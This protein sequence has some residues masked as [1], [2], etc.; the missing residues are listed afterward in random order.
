MYIDICYTEFMT[1]EVASVPEP[2]K[3]ISQ[4]RERTE[5]SQ[6][7]SGEK[8]LANYLGT[9]EY[10]DKNSKVTTYLQGIM[11][12]LS[13]GHPV[14]VIVVH[15][16]SANAFVVSGRVVVHD[17]LLRALDTHE[18]I[19]GILDHE[20]THIQKGHLNERGKDLIGEVGVKRSNET[21]ADF[22]PLEH[23]DQKGINPAGLM[24]AFQKIDQ[25]ET[26]KMQEKSD[27]LLP[28]K[29]K[30]K[31]GWE[32][33]RSKKKISLDFE[34]GS[35][36]DRKLNLEEAAWLVDIRNLSHEMTLHEITNENLEEYQKDQDIWKDFRQFSLDEKRHFLQRQITKLYLSYVPETESDRREFKVKEEQLIMWQKEVLHEAFPDDTD[37]KIETKMLSLFYFSYL[38]PLNKSVNITGNEISLPSFLKRFQ[39]EDVIRD[40]FKAQE[41]L[42][43]T[44]LS[45]SIDEDRLRHAGSYVFYQRLIK[46]DIVDIPTYLSLVQALPE[47]QQRLE[48]FFEPLIEVFMERNQITSDQTIQHLAAN[49]YEIPFIILNV[50]SFLDRSPTRKENIVIE[51]IEG[52]PPGNDIG[53]THKENDSSYAPTI[54]DIVDYNLSLAGGRLGQEIQKL[55]MRKI[56]SFSDPIDA[57]IYTSQFPDNTYNSV[58]EYS[59]TNG[60][61]S[62]LRVVTESLPIP[63]LIKRITALSPDE[64]R[65]LLTPDFKR[66]IESMYF[67]ESETSLEDYYEDSHKKPTP[68]SIIQRLELIAIVGG[69]NNFLDRLQ[70]DMESVE[71]FSTKMSLAQ[72]LDFLHAIQ[73]IPKELQNKGF[74]IEWEIT[75]EDINCSFFLRKY[76]KEIALKEARNKN[77]I[78]GLVETLRSINIYNL[79]SGNSETWEKLVEKV[80]LKG[81]D[82][83]NQA[84]LF[85]LL[86]LGAISESTQVMLQIPEKAIEALFRKKS[87]DKSLDFL[88]TYSHLPH[89]IFRSGL[90]YLIEEKARTL[91]DFAKLESVVQKEIM[92]FL[93]NDTLIGQVALAD[94]FLIQPAKQMGTRR[95]TVASRT[96]EL[97]GA[98]TG[99]LLAALLASGGND[100][101][102]KEYIFSRWWMKQRIFQKEGEKDFDLEDLS[103]LRQKGKEGRL[104]FWI[105]KM[106]DSHYQTLSGL[107]TNVYLANDALRYAALRKILLGEGGVLHSMEGREQL[108]D[109]FL[110]SKVDFQ[111]SNGGEIIT[112]ELLG[113]LL[114]AGNEEELYQRLAPVLSE[115]I[116]KIPQE[117]FSYQELAKEQAYHALLRM[118][119][120]RLISDPTFRDW[121]VLQRRLLHLMLGGK[122][123]E[124]TLDLSKVESQMLVL[125]AEKDDREINATYTPWGLAIAAGEKA[126]AVGVRMLQLAGQYFD[127]PAELHDRLMNVYDNNK[128]QSR[129]QAYRVLRRE[130]ELIP[131]MRQFLDQVKE[132]RP[133]IGGGSLVTVYE[134]MLKNGKREA[135]AVKNPNVSYHV[136]K[137]ENLL[138]R[139]VNEAMAQHPDN[140]NYRLLSVLL[141]DVEEW[142]NN[143]LEDPRFE[144]KD[145]EFRLANDTRYGQYATNEN[146]YG[147]LVPESVPTGTRWVRRDEF[148]EGKNLT[149]LTI[150]DG[151]TDIP[152]GKISQKDYKKATVVLV[153]NYVHQIMVTGL[154]HSDVHPG[155]FR[156]TADNKNIAIFD[157]YNLL[158]LNSNEK[159]LIQGIIFMFASENGAGIRE[160]FIDYAME[161][162]ENQSG[163]FTKNFL[164]SELEKVSMNQGIEKIILDS[165]LA[166]KQKGM[167]IPLK[168]SLIGKNLQ[169]LNRMAQTAG[170][171]NLLACYFSE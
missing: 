54:T 155:N 129:L 97:K 40:L 58:D 38:I 17:G 79:P 20:W 171:D 85:T 121:E 44:S 29:H 28:R 10:Y 118:R 94:T 14:D 146:T 52:S 56:Q 51:R 82:T 3:R 36:E 37:D 125:F 62:A 98:S 6:K 45:F 124:S 150:T 104:E 91:E 111:S 128:G 93:H 68:A 106:P 153:K 145:N 119:E 78:A 152:D 48:Y 163:N 66:T 25:Y 117:P 132:I 120:D 84:H 157:R 138:Q 154:V 102:L 144:E 42:N 165:V 108:A 2:E 113:A 16:D 114:N 24:S 39:S 148:I 167:K 133:R 4:K 139:T 1:I 122:E 30:Q 87:L 141:S 103:F 115:M 140:E 43:A 76:L 137:T 162:E 32:K 107:V 60:I 19:A 27:A 70:W 53:K 142:I 166:L 49:I 12:L 34:H 90:N 47:D 74:P 50:V 99:E 96:T 147:I 164:I 135:V 7:V 35:L 158:E 159:A 89:H 169:A 46:Q 151:A 109:A 116:L 86:A 81:V 131:E 80:L 136:A 100:K 64:R 123:S 95:S 126:G 73:S 5:S 69:K 8:Y 77:N 92:Q 59:Y 168:V 112:K 26:Q 105:N 127:V 21:E 156:I 15:D 65:K 149:S 23:L 170:F 88:Q 143:E 67:T 71:D 18:E 61:D 57:I 41:E 13:D 33:D 75:R 22:L 83:H 55:R 63:N 134:V 101:A 160:A 72:G 31:R 130:A 11:N 161:I 110:Q 9:H